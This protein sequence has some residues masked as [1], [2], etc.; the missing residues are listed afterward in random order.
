M[1]FDLP[2]IYHDQTPSDRRLIRLQ[3]I[4]E[5]NNICHF[6]KHDLH[7]EPAATITSKKINLSLFP[8]HFLSHP[9]HLQHDHETRLTEGAVHA[10]C[11]AIMWQ[12]HGK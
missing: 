12:Y 10:F 5:Q 2:V 1:K 6:C 4:A 8:Q 3:Y 11:N 9:I 7:S